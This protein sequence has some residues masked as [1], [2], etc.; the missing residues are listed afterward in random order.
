MFS[1]LPLKKSYSAS[2]LALSSAFFW[3]D[4]LIIRAHKTI[5]H[6][7]SATIRERHTTVFFSTEVQLSINPGALLGLHFTVIEKSLLDRNIDL[8]NLYSALWMHT[9]ISILNQ[10][11]NLYSLFTSESDSSGLFL[12]SQ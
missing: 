6:L 4:S 3:S 7:T 9:K 12:Q 10:L 2:R 11:R 5:F 1:C 8:R